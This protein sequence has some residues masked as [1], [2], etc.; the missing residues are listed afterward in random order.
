M[1]NNKN[2]VGWCHNFYFEICSEMVIFLCPA[3]FI[4]DSRK[5]QVDKQTK[6]FFHCKGN[7]TKASKT[8]TKC[9]V[10]FRITCVKQDRDTNILIIG[11]NH[12]VPLDVPSPNQQCKRLR[13]D[14]ENFITFWNSAKCDQQPRSKFK[15]WQSIVSCKQGYSKSSSLPIA[16]GNNTSSL[17]FTAVTFHK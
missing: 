14:E 4:T 11:K 7:R 8:W 3:S 12:L 17:L 9:F 15:R 1:P 5:T 10:S 13:S 16:R 2:L 6:C